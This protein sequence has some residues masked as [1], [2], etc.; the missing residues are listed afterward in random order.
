MIHATLLRFRFRSAFAFNADISFWNVSSVRDISTV[1]YF[2]WCAT[3]WKFHRNVFA[4]TEFRGG[5]LPDVLVRISRGWAG[6]WD[7]SNIWLP[8][9]LTRNL[10]FLVWLYANDASINNINQCVRNE[11]TI[12]NSTGMDFREATSFNVDLSIW[13]VSRCRDLTGAFRNATDFDQK[14]CWK[15]REDAMVLRMFCGSKGGAISENCVCKQDLYYDEKC[16]R[17]SL[18]AELTCDP[19]SL[20]ASGASTCWTQHLVVLSSGLAVALAAWVGWWD[21]SY[22]Q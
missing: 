4:L 10:A 14:L 15:F 21:R 9:L 6:W 7:V 3:S 8:S 17:P 12:C 16:V 19:A 11:P 5:L 13:D 18:L 1:S 2:A 20:Q 22:S